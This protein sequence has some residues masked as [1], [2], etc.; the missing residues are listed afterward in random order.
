MC[1][2]GCDSVGGAWLREQG[3]WVGV[4]CLSAWTGAGAVVCGG[5][6]SARANLGGG[7]VGEAGVGGRGDIWE[8]PSLSHAVC[9]RWL[10]C[11]GSVARARGRLVVVV[12]RRA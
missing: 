10:C 12:P 2:G 3:K 7:D 8:G 4:E 9:G 5:G 11:G 6:V 1:D